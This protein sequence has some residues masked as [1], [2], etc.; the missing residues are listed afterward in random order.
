MTDNKNFVRKRRYPQEEL[1]RMGKEIYEKKIRPLVEDGNKG[2]I[3]A[4]DIES[5]TY[6]MCGSGDEIDCIH[7]LLK[8][9]HD[10]QIWLVRIGH[11]E[12]YR[13]SWRLL[14]ETKTVSRSYR[15]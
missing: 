3:V 10:A 4:I 11:E 12:V 13:R 1:A 15:S 5:G 9:N 2:K 6:E 14:N 7:Q 8:K